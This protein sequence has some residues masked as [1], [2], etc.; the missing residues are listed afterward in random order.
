MAADKLQV[1]PSG[2]P[3]LDK[4]QTAVAFAVD[5][6]LKNPLLAGRLLETETDANGHEIEIVLTTTARNIAHKLGRKYRGWF[7]IDRNADARVWVD[8]PVGVPLV[9]PNPDRER[10]LR[11]DASATVTVKIWVF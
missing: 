8:P 9:D 3:A 7:I 2:D 5:P 6:L 4:F 10:F 1:N 11:L